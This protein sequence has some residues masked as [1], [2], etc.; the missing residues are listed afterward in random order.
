M[1][2]QVASAGL[3]LGPSLPFFSGRASRT[4]SF[5]G[6]PK[7]QL[8]HLI[9][10]ILEISFGSKSNLPAPTLGCKQPFGDEQLHRSLPSS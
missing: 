10:V 5:L 6:R 8:A 4:E 9:Q 3:R 7:L 1:S 2:C